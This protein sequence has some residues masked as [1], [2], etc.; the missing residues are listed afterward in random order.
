MLG[1]ALQEA[2]T[3][4][5]ENSKGKGTDGGSWHSVVLCCDSDRMECGPV[6]THQETW[7]ER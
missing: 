4:G 5:R 2:G 1:Q 7:P 3:A 6:R